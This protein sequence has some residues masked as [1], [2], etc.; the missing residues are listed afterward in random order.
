MC[1]IS[2]S[3]KIIATSSPPFNAQE[4]SIQ[5]INVHQSFLTMY[6]SLVPSISVLK[7]E[8]REPGP[9]LS[10]LWAVTYL[11]VEFLNDLCMKR[12][13]AK[14]YFIIGVHSFIRSLLLRMPDALSPST[15]FWEKLVGAPPSLT[16]NL[17]QGHAQ[18][19]HSQL[20]PFGF[21][22]WFP[23]GVWKGSLGMGLIFRLH[24][25]A[26]VSKLGT[27]ECTEKKRPKS[28]RWESDF[29]LNFE[30]VISFLNQSFI[31]HYS[32]PFMSP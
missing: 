16:Q 32:G 3:G 14:A 26:L 8:K 24:F 13:Q 11:Y 5:S 2:A 28:D 4:K 30:C 19:T 23:F 21:L 15:A 22:L 1:N 20:F 6:I 12:L 29:Q 25:I 9:Q 18:A 31:H 17:S 7:G 10:N 27:L